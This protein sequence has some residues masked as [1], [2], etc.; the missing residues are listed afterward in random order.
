MPL[1]DF[2]AF[3]RHLHV[4]VNSKIFH[5]FQL[6]VLFFPTFNETTMEAPLFLLFIVIPCNARS[7]VSMFYF[8]YI[9]KFHVFLFYCMLCASCN[10]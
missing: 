9:L 8:H 2:E 5:C 3:Y 7:R 1:K 4:L 6:T 10:S